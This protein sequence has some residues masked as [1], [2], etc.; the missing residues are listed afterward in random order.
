MLVNALFTGILSLSLASFCSANNNIPAPAQSQTIMLRGATI[1]TVSGTTIANGALVFSDGKITA[2]G[3]AGDITLPAGAREINLTGKHIYPGLISGNSALGL[4]ETQ[5]VRATV[6]TLEIGAINPNM[7]ALVAI[8]A[9]SELLPVTRANGVLTALAVPAPDRGG[10]TSGLIAGTS[11]L[12]ALDGWNWQQMSLLNEAGL[13]VFLPSLRFSPSLF[14]NMPP[15]RLEDLQKL[16]EGQLKTLENA[17]ES[18]AAYIKAKNAD[19]S[20]ATDTR[21]ESMREVLGGKRT[22]FIHADELQQLR[23]ALNFGQRFKLKIAIIG[24]MDAP[25]LAPLLKQQNVPVIIAGTHRLP[26]RRGDSFDAPYRVAAQLHEAGVVA[27]EGPHGVQRGHEH[28]VDAA[29]D[30]TE[31]HQMPAGR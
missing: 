25:L 26:M 1:H 6:D 7:R 14:P 27:I 18:A 5:S 24:G 4:V 17:F 20:H 28:A 16:N 29:A 13:H 9:D 12:I 22:V 8:N 3:N 10:M 15:K 31:G 19:A 2:L 23:Y 11:A 30:R 21:W